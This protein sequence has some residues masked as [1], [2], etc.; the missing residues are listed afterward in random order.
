M[1]SRSDRQ[2]GGDPLL[3]VEAA[4]ALVLFALLYFLYLIPSGNPDAAVE[5]R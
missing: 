5:P 4:L 2:P 3:L 1:E